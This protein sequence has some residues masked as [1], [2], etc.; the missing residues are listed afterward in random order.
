MGPNEIFKRYVMETE[1]TLILAEEH[2]VIVGG[3]YARKETTQKIPRP[4][5]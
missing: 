2:E 4:N 1:R 5:L 3:H